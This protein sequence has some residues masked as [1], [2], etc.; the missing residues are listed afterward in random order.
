M[1]KL[2]SSIEDVLDLF[3]GEGLTVPVEEV[4]GQYP[5]LFPY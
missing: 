1:L 4:I 3:L 5:Y 2:A